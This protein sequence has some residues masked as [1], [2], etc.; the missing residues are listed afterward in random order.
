V[1]R[2]TVAGAQVL[3]VGGYLGLPAVTPEGLADLFGFAKAKGVQTVLDVIVPSTATYRASDVL[4]L[5][6]PHT[7]VFLP[8]ADEATLLTGEVEPERQADELLELGCS[9][10][11]ITMGEMGVLAKSATHTVRAGAFDVDAV[12]PSGAGDAFDAGFIVG[13]LN[14]WSLVKTVKFACALGASATLKSGCTPGVFTMTEALKF[15]DE[16]D[17]A[18]VVEPSSGFVS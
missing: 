13:M 15:I 2:H 6:L 7:D 1:D 12:D 10:A 14:E 11:V 17:L 4:G 16:N 9:C 5:V 3:Y 18:V 8:N